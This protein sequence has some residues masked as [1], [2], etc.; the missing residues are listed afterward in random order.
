MYKLA[1]KDTDALMKSDSMTLYKDLESLDQ[2]IYKE[3]RVKRKRQNLLDSLSFQLKSNS[4]D[5]DELL[6]LTSNLAQRYNTLALA[7]KDKC[8]REA[9]NYFFF[10]SKKVESFKK[11]KNLY[12]N[13]VKLGMLK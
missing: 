13:A 8:P 12:K 1:E 5:Y 10:D 9:D 4:E 7:F 6:Q 3:G 11:G 2:I